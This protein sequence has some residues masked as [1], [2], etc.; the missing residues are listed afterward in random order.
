MDEDRWFIRQVMRE[1]CFM[2][3][4]LLHGSYRVS[5]TRRLSRHTRPLARLA[6]RDSTHTQSIAIDAVLEEMCTCGD[7][8]RPR[9][10]IRSRYQKVSTR[11]YA[12]I[13][14][15]RARVRNSF[16]A[17]SSFFSFAH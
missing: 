2:R 11:A 4:L 1:A 12:C 6:N 8:F 3:F 5:E 7:D 10:E 9:H 17:C 13:Q 14:R 16:K 15:G